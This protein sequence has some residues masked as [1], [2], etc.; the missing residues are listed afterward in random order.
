MNRKYTTELVQDILK[1]YN[2]FLCDDFISI[3]KEIVCKDNDGY[4][5]KCRLND[6]KRGKTPRKFGKSNPYTINN[7]HTYIK[8]NNI[9]VKLI[10][11]V[12]TKSDTKLTWKCKCGN[13]YEAS[14]NSFYYSNKH[15][16]N[17]CGLSKITRKRKFNISDI[18]EILTNDGYKLLEHNIDDNIW[19]NYIDLED[20]LGYRYSCLL[21]TIIEH[22]T[23]NKFYNSNKFSIYN[24]NRWLNF[25][26]M[27]D[28]VCLSRRYTS[29]SDKL[30]FIHLTC[31]TVFCASLVEMKD[32]KCENNKDLR[33]KKCPYCYENL[34]ESRHAY[35]LKQIFIHEH[36]DTIVEDRSCYN[37]KTNYSLPT[38]IV[39]HRLKI[40]IE[41]QSSF[42]D[43]VYQQQKDAYKKDYWINKGY[44]FYAL[45]IRD[46]SI[47]EMIQIFFLNISS[48]PSY[49]KLTVDL[50]TQYKLLQDY[51]DIG[52]ST[53]EISNIT[54]LKYSYIYGLVY[55]GILSL[56]EQ[57]KE[58]VFNI[59]KIV[60]LSKDNK[61]IRTFDSISD[62]NRHGYKY[63]TIRRVLIGK[64]EYSYGCKWMYEEDY[65]QNVNNI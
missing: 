37:P 4:L 52:Y 51:L 32:K 21:K 40:A 17:A 56:P 48:I 35:I 18:R 1:A 63:G 44:S 41:V 58:K 47:V 43:N 34:S 36:P 13:I 62:A 14:W 59:R 24:I 20:K 25:N 19:H 65:L 33:Y 12:F 55:R 53:R 26:G 30:K 60:Q 50:D 42:H 46:Y 57:Y 22:R 16:C 23:P 10:S 54:G 5:Y 15:Q 39:N 64:Q 45:D 7:I 11:D 3:D 8:A 27:N 6:V 38:D 31:G 29:N 9:H 2:L 61:Y 28:Y 49:V